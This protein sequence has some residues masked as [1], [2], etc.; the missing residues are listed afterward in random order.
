MGST[1]SISET[2]KTLRKR[3]RTIRYEYY[4]LHTYTYLCTFLKY[5]TR[6]KQRSTFELLILFFL[7][8]FV[9]V[10][11]SIRSFCYIQQVL[12]ILF[13]LTLYSPSDIC[14]IESGIRAVIVSSLILLK[15][16]TAF[17]IYSSF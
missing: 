3:E 4:R 1:H 17:R 14:F 13:I 11:K 10:K 2:T 15:S 5:C 16:F 6:E 8:C 7:L 9:R 12:F